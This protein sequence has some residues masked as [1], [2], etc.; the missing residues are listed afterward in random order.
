MP[1][2]HNPLT[3]QIL[4]IF[5]WHLASRTTTF[6]MYTLTSLPVR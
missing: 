5:A 6:C 4:S 2:M 3:Y 1:R